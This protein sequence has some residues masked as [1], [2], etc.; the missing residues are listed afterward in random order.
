MTKS[1]SDSKISRSNRKC[2][3]RIKAW[4]LDGF[5]CV[6]SRLDDGGAEPVHQDQPGAGVGAAVGRRRAGHRL[7]AAAHH[8]HAGSGGLVPVPVL[9]AGERP[10]GA[11]RQLHPR[12]AHRLHRLLAVRYDGS[13]PGWGSHT[14][15][16]NQ[17]QMTSW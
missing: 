15:R 7:P 6:L 5:L 4:N 12:P 10:A 9:A 17:N 16:T 1:K 14:A 13:E 8:G 3:F 2:S 11:Q